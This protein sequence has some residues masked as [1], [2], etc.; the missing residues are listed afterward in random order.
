MRRSKREHDGVFR[1]RGLQLEVELLAEALAQR[2]TPGAIDPASEWR[3][4][5]ELHSARLVEEPLEHEGLP[6]RHHA[7]RG[8]RGR[9]ILD[10]LLRP[11]LHDANLGNEPVEP[12]LMVQ[13]LPRRRSAAQCC[14]CEARL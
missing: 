3:V 5:D 10:D 1:R 2:E 14:R 6:A 7:Q 4:Q 9:K 12:G 11:G 13:G 8:V